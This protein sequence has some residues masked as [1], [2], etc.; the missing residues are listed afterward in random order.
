MSGRLPA[1]LPCANDLLARLERNSAHT[2]AR[3]IL[4]AIDHNS[5][6]IGR[7]VDLRMLLGIPVRDW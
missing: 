1:G 6:H 3:Q 5:Y 4:L 7:L 2:P